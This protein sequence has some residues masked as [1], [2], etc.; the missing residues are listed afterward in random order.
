MSISAATTLIA[1]PPSPSLQS[2]L[3]DQDER[4]LAQLATLVANYQATLL[5]NNNNN[6]DNDNNNDGV[7]DETLQH[8][9][10]TLTTWL[11]QA[12]AAMVSGVPNTNTTTTTTTSTTTTT[13][14]TTTFLGDDWWTTIQRARMTLVVTRLSHCCRRNRRS[15]VPRL[16]QSVR[17]LLHDEYDNEYNQ[18]NDEYEYDDNPY[19]YDRLPSC[20][21][22][23]LRSSGNS[24]GAA[25]LVTDPADS[26]GL[27]EVPHYLQQ[28]QQQQ[29][30][31]HHQPSVKRQRQAQPHYHA[32]D[33]DD[34]WQLCL[35]YLL[36]QWI[37][38]TLQLEP[39]LT[40]QPV[41]VQAF[42]QQVL[43]VAHIFTI[44]T[45]A[46]HVATAWFL[47]DVLTDPS[48]AV[49]RDSPPLDVILEG[50]TLEYLV[51]ELTEKYGGGMYVAT[52]KN[53]G[54]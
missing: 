26:S 35:S 48:H 24:S 14:T 33:P 3:L 46:T 12:Q 15:L 29:Q 19:N 49:A 34:S 36:A 30:Y 9:D 13:G 43:H 2:L 10:A 31:A 5:L 45:L 44:P 27:W 25:A 52:K 18:D 23:W 50:V 51:T 7:S 17:R 42:T 1:T 53:E 16:W 39:P 21:T 6:N 40:G 38:E 32:D 4:I 54:R 8:M 22:L 47:F 41:T 20:L 11:A 28:Q 37:F